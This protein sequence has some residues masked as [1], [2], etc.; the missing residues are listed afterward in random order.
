MRNF[1]QNHRHRLVTVGL[2]LGVVMLLIGGLFFL[3][4]AA[5]QAIQSGRAFSSSSF[6][7]QSFNINGEWQDS[8]TFS[9]VTFVLDITQ[10][11]NIATMTEVYQECT[12]HL[13][14]PNY[15]YADSYTATAQL[16]DNAG[17]GGYAVGDTISI[18]SSVQWW[19][20]DHWV[21][22]SAMVWSGTLNTDGSMTLQS[23]GIT[24]N[25][26]TILTYHFTPTHNAISTWKNT[27]NTG[28]TC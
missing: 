18:S 23:N 9:D 10:S 13:F 1:V 16:Q 19:D 3:A 6:L 4:N 24:S 27:Y 8:S 22:N 28:A 26:Q 14:S 5:K 12:T 21:E 17:S 7:S 2:I 15:V 25:N 20:V 11:G